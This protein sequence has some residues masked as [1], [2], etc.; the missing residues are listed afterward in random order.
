MAFCIVGGAHSFTGD[1]HKVCVQF[2]V[3]VFVV[4]YGHGISAWLAVRKV[5]D[6][7]SVG[8]QGLGVGQPQQLS[9]G[10]KTW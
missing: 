4:E 9:P 1:S 8:D 2:A 10:E 5:A 7:V 3:G 6:G